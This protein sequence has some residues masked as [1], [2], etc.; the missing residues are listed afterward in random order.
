MVRGL[1][2]TACHGLA[3]M[4]TYRL[5]CKYYVIGF[6]FLQACAVDTAFTRPGGMQVLMTKALWLC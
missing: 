4:G 2:Y 1:P 3:C 5:A 6:F